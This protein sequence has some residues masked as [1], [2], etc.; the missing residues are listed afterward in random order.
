M[1]DKAPVQP[2]DKIERVSLSKD[3]LF[4]YSTRT[5]KN[6]EKINKPAAQQS[7]ISR[8]RSVSRSAQFPGSEPGTQKDSPP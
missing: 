7:K 5:G 2:K 4:R 8:D 1:T 6:T 3:C